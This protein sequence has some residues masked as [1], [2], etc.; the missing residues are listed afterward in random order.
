MK[1]KWLLTHPDG[2]LMI[3]KVIKAMDLSIYDRVIITIVKPHIAQYDARTILEQA[4]EGN[5]YELCILDDFTSCASETVHQTLIRSH[6]QGPFVVRDADNMVKV[7]IGK[8]RNFVVGLNL[9]TCPD[10][11]NITGKSFIVVNEQNTVINIIE[12][13]ITSNIISVGVYGFDSANNFKNALNEINGLGNNCNELYISHIIAY[14]IGTGKY[15]FDYIPADY[16]EDWGTLNDWEK[17][18]NRY[19]TFFIDIDGVI[20]KNSG[21]YGHINW[22]NNNHILKDNVEVIKQLQQQGAELVFVTCRPEQYRQRLENM[23][24]RNGLENFRIITGLNHAQRVLINDFAP[25]NPYPSC[26]AINVPRNANI[27]DYLIKC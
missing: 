16:F 13:T 8:L 3:D 19:R 23:L 2:Q 21:K 22:D 20:L 10:I 9:D 14:M 27:A 5:G 4:F 26:T 1:P 6:I 15:Q 12:K 25:T 17:V 11:S 24:K 18:R 7:K